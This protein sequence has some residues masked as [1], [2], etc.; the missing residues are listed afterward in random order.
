LLNPFASIYTA[1][2]QVADP[3]AVFA[4]GDFVT[5]VLTSSISNGGLG[6]VQA[7]QTYPAQYAMAGGNVTLHAGENIERKTQNNNG[8]VDD[9]SRQLPNNWLY[10]RGYVGPNGEFGSVTV[11]TGFI[12]FN[13]PAASTSWWVDHSNFFQSVGALGGGDVT[14]IAGNEVRNVDA[15]IPTNARA[16]RGTPD[17]SKIVELGGG[18]LLVRTGGDISGGVYYVERGVGRLEAGGSVTTNAARSP[19]LGIIQNLNNPAAAQFDPLT[20]MP[21]TLFLG[22]SSFDVSARGD[23]LLG[24]MANAFLLP[25]GLNNR[26]WYK[27]Y[28]STFGEESSVTATSLG[29]DVSL[30]N[31]VTLPQRASSTEIFRAW[32]ETQ[33]LL[34]TGSTG[35][36]FTQPWLRLSETSVD[37]FAS[38]LSLRPSSIITTALEGDV[39][40]V[41]NITLA[42][43]P[44]GQLE[45]VAAGSVNALQPTGRS[46]IISPGQSV[47]A[48]TAASINVSDA[49]PDA[50]PGVINPF[51]YFGLV[52]SSTNANNVTRAGFLEPIA[53]YF[54]DSS[55]TTGSFGVATTKQALHDSG[56][57]HRN[58]PDP[59]RIYALGGNLSGLT[60]FSP[61]PSRINAARD[62][63][64]VSFYLQNLDDADAT[65]ITAGRD[66]I[67]Y[68]ASSALRTAALAPGNFPASGQLPSA[69]DIHLGGPG[70]L[71]VLAGRNLDLGTGTTNADGSG[72]GLLSI[73]NTRNPFLP[74]AGAD[75]FAGAGVGPAASLADSRLKI[76]AFVRDFVKTA[77]GRAHLRELGVSNF[78][79]LD[80][81]EQAQV[82]MEVFYLFLRDAG[83]DF[84]NEDSPDFGTYDQGFAAIRSLFGGNGYDGD[85][86]TRGRSI[87]T[88][89]GGD[90]NLFAPGGSLTL[91]NTTIGNPLVPPGIVTESGG[92][93]S[94]FT[95][96]SVDIGVGRIFTLRGGDMMIW[97]SK[98]DIAAGVASKTVQSAPPTRVLIDPQSAAVETDLAGLATGGGI[99]VLATVAGIRPG[100]VDL[101]APAGIID[102]GDAGIRVT[103]NINLAAT[104]VLNSSNIAAGGS[105][106]GAPSAP[107]VSTPSLG[108][109]TA[110][111]SSTAA[112]STAAM[113]AGDS[114]RDQNTAAAETATE[115]LTPSVITVEVLGYGGGG[116]EEE[117]DEEDQ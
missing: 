17:A 83:R 23:V 72:S 98:G 51:N 21:T 59:L 78:D 111:A 97:S 52:G 113:D 44:R 29:G 16:P 5:P 22:R 75:L 94:I 80:N 31:A 50:I 32:L 64:D 115:D 56:L 69:G 47:L 6:T 86:L 18:D 2:T 85:L 117:E 66:I 92:R 109:L 105:S 67:P 116:G 102:A 4:P 60:L 13:D 74:F 101:I 63:T 8:L 61:K 57:L 45:I 35:A 110:G 30:R 3:T 71:Q 39:N 40:L 12:T 41:G 79:A 81:E 20:W 33:N 114:A 62:I 108:G 95:R 99:G 34:A 76:D 10:R 93:V 77:E 107:S 58:D 27:T 88:Q 65:I 42:P 11:G 46:S 89:N 53:R 68:N 103:G 28:F 104:Q 25:Q 38:L 9:S 7:N 70:S 54:N 96:D 26:F 73:G 19:S 43:S 15:V 91:A 48:W 84:N 87:R 106:S 112:A 100:N 14:M 82:A 49:D 90:I 37:P 55:S 1:G 24:P 36:A